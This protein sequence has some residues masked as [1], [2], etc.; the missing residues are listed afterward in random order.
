MPQINFGTLTGNGRSNPF[1]VRADG[2]VSFYGVGTYDGAT[3]TLQ[4]SLDA[5]DNWYDVGDDTG[6]A[7][8]TDSGMQ[9]VRLKGDVLLAASVSGT[10]AS[11]SIDAGL[12]T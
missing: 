8:F 7:S 10:G 3:L 6:T 11:T 2:F 5:G 4:F 12:L 9:V 1:P